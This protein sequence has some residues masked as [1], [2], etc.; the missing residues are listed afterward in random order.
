MRFR[1]YKTFVCKCSSHL[2]LIFFMFF[3]TRNGN[4]TVV[5]TRPLGCSNFQLLLLNKISCYYFKLRTSNFTLLVT[6]HIL[7]GKYFLKYD[8]ILP[9]DFIFRYSLQEV[10]CSSIL[11]YSPL[12][13]SLTL[14]VSGGGFS[15]PQ[16]FP[17][18]PG[19]DVGRVTG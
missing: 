5:T 2:E 14:P 6:T 1:I 19:L 9:I 16:Q 11:H 12:S 18:S 13:L 10:M 3:C 4:V 8:Y 17:F 15:P 7:E